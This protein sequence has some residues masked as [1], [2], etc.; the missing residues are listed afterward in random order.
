MGVR[1]PRCCWVELSARRS[2][3]PRVPL[4]LSP[5]NRLTLAEELVH[6]L[7]IAF[8][9]LGF[10]VW[11]LASLLCIPKKSPITI[12]ITQLAL[13]TQPRGLVHAGQTL[14]SPWHNRDPFFTYML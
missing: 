13:P 2:I 6:A 12:P 11:G 10:R 8:E 14:Q 9:G 1:T 7:G 4:I 3:S 5:I